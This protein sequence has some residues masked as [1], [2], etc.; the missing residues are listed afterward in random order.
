MWKGKKG[1]AGGSG[2]EEKKEEDKGRK[3]EEGPEVEGDYHDHN[4]H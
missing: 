1:E 2:G 4:Q 3:E